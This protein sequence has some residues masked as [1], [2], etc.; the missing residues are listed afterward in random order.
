MGN[1]LPTTELQDAGGATLRRLCVYNGGF[2]T[3]KRVRQLLKGAGFRTAL[4][5]PR[6]GDAVGVWGQSPTSHRGEAIAAKYGAPIVRVEDAFLRSL[7]PG[8]SG[9]PPV[10]L[11]IDQTGLHF[12]PSSP[13][14][15]ETLLKTHPLDDGALM[16]RARAGMARMREAHL[17]KYSAT[18]PSLAP[19][20]PGYV[21][22]VDQTVGD[23]SVRA[24]R[25][26]RSRFLE[27]LFVAQEENPG[28]RIVIK[29]HPETTAGFRG[30][31]YRSEDTTDKIVL[32]D[33]PLS[34]YQLLEGAV[35]VYTLSSQM[36]FEAIIAGH[37]PRVF[38]GPFYAGWGLTTDE[39]VFAR[40]RRDLSR[41]QLFAAAMLLYPQ[42]F[43]PYANAPGSFEDALGAVEAQTRAWRED[44]DGWVATGMRLW[45]RQ[46][47]QRA[48]GSQRPVIYQN[49]RVKACETAEKTDRKVMEWAGKAGPG[50]VRVEDGFLRSRGLG[51]ALVPAMSLVLD[52]LGIYYDPSQPSRLEQLIQGA[53]AGL[54][55][56]QIERSERLLDRFLRAGLSKYNLSGDLP[57]LPS[58]HR[59]L[60]PGQVEDDASILTGSSQV[61]TNSELLR[62]T[63]EANPDAVIVWKPHPDVQAGLRTGLVDN[64]LKWADIALENC[65]ISDLLQSV[66]EVWTMTSL[67]GFEGLLRGCRVTTL[68][69]PFYA[70]WGLT[71]DLGTIPERRLQGARPDLNALIHAVLID[72]PRYF[73]PVTGL[74]CPVETIIERLQS[75]SIPHPGIGNRLLS[76]LQGAFASQAHLWRR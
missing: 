65:D 36:G 27:M 6:T 76:K 12:D 47:L 45:K 31:H 2:L 43:D 56:D 29:T 49:D 71:R 51:A 18:D 30:G 75:G 59:I 17:S 32:C 68:G 28:A 4:G 23:A 73:D 34:P 74:A 63:R 24:S 33:A 64:P 42:W 21:L 53:A 9:E 52:D 35:A 3:Q 8:R 14:D 72:Y 7:H 10:G 37:K 50:T 40:R 26:N 44:K 62:V 25:G 69:A 1:R 70:G 60:V 58:G 57:T 66:D 38:G 19:P 46:P 22:V 41:S 67:T 13:S 39:D 55:V 54:R 16:S 61:T 15:L 11:L 20:A 48:F 5:I